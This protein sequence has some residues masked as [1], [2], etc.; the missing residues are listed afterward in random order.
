MQFISFYFEM[1]H[2][3]NFPLKLLKP[4]GLTIQPDQF[5]FPTKNLKRCPFQMAPKIEPIGFPTEIAKGSFWDEETQTL[6][7]VDIFKHTIHSY[8]PNTDEHHSTVVG[9]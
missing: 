5:L 3:L 1:N 9:E 4:Y 2:I 7:F 6:F 8:N